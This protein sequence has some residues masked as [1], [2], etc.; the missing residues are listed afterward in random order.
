MT[1]KSVTHA[2]SNQPSREASPTPNRD[3]SQ[4]RAVDQTELAAAIGR[5]HTITANPALVGAAASAAPGGVVRR[6]R[7]RVI[8]DPSLGFIIDAIERT[9]KRIMDEVTATRREVRAVRRSADENGQMIKVLWRELGSPPLD[10]EDEEME[11]PDGSQPQ[12]MR[13]RRWGL[14]EK[15][16]DVARDIFEIRIDLEEVARETNKGLEALVRDIGTIAD[17]VGL[18]PSA[19]NSRGGRD[20]RKG[21]AEPERGRAETADQTWDEII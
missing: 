20:K 5:P 12:Q 8:G 21:R 17:A 16:D 4:T 14:R 9:E 15:L 18:A 11:E 1:A 19:T 10:E 7:A 2:G 3:I 13:R 6:G